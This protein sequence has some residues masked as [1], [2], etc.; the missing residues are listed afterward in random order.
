M[1]PNVRSVKYWKQRLAHPVK[2]QL[3]MRRKWPG[4]QQ[5]R[6]LL[7]S[8]AVATLQDTMCL[9]RKSELVVWQKA[10]VE[11]WPQADQANA[12]APCAAL[13][14]TRA[15]PRSDPEKPGRRREGGLYYSVDYLGFF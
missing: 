6:S 8:W 12:S 15:N 7:V 14:R 5:P 4:G 11:I 2:R 13:Q 9:R 10:K 3:D 1:V